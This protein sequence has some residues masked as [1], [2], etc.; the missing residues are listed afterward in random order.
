MDASV[1]RGVPES[2]EPSPGYAPDI[3]INTFDLTT[4]KGCTSS[5]S[6]DL[7]P[8]LCVLLSL[9]HGTTVPLETKTFINLKNV[10][11]YVI[12]GLSS[13]SWKY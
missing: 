13:Q 12:D 10:I 1:Q 5:L 9:R 6:T 4:F 7:I 8:N 3:K 2:L 11:A